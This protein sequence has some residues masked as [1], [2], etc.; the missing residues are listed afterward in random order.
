M[1]EAEQVYSRLFLSLWS[2][3]YDPH[4]HLLE[5]H[6]FGV[7]TQA[8]IVATTVNTND[9]TKMQTKELALT[10]RV[11]NVSHPITRRY[12]SDIIP[13]TTTLL[14]IS[15]SKSWAFDSTSSMTGI[16]MGKLTNNSNVSLELIFLDAMRIATKLVCKC[17][18][19]SFRSCRRHTPL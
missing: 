4:P 16:A 9:S 13:S 2:G 10:L 3:W 19:K 12:D 14:T 8:Q 5:E 7:P 17:M 6:L 11:T 18:L 1:V 15:G